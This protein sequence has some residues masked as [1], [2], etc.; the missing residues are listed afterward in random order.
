MQTINLQSVTGFDVIDKTKPV[1]IRDGNYKLFYSTEDLTPKVTKFNL[2]KGMYFFDTK[3]FRESKTVKKYKKLPTPSRERFKYKLPIDFNVVFGANA[4]K[5]S[6]LWDK[7]T[8]IF[9][10]SCKEYSLSEL[11]FI[12]Y[13]EFGHTFYTTEQYCDLYSYNKMI[14]KGFNPSQIARAQIFSLSERQEKRKA[15]LTDLIINT[16]D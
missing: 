9:D 4:N 5:C 2:P 12:F 11:Y 6:I 14:E 16:N 8:I 13:H 15:F 7:K 1:I 3:N 10:K